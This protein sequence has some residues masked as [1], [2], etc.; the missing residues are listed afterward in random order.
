MPEALRS[1]LTRDALAPPIE[2]TFGPGRLG[3]FN[4]DLIR[5][6]PAVKNGIE[7]KEKQT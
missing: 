5:S 7:T 6:F 1:A 4:Q 2:A 3:W